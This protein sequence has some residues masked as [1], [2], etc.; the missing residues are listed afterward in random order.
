VKFGSVAAKAVTF[1]SSTSLTAVSPEEL[2]GK[3]AVTVTTAN[4]TSEVTKKDSFT[5]KKP[6]K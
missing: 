5:F 6:K 4:G 3:V 2:P 1:I